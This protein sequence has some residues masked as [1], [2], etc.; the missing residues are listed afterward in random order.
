[1]SLT[2]SSDLVFLLLVLTVFLLVLWHIPA[3]LLKVLSLLAVFCAA[4]VVFLIV[5]TGWSA[6]PSPW[7]RAV[8]GDKLDKYELS[9]RL[10][11]ALGRFLFT[12]IIA[13]L[14]AWWGYSNRR[15]GVAF[16][17]LTRGIVIALILAA[18]QFFRT[19]VGRQLLGV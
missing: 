17:G 10:A 11:E 4:C 5:T 7:S 1:M 12:Y 3:L 19:P 15:T 2:G 16:P 18:F 6:G 13:A 8:Y 9:Y 14:F